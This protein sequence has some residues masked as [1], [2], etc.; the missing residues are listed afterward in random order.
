MGRGPVWT[1]P[2]SPTK[3]SHHL[4]SGPRTENHSSRDREQKI[5]STRAGDSDGIGATH[6]SNWDFSSHHAQQVENDYFVGTQNS[7]SR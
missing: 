2:V 3:N 7:T 5:S 1:V 6:T 4:K